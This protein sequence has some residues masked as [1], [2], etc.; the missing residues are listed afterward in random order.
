MI[1]KFI[2]FLLVV[3][4]TCFFA[5]EIELPFELSQDKSI[6]FLKLPMENQKDSLLFFFDTGA[7]IALLDAKKAIELGLEANTTNQVSGAGGEKT[8]AMIQNYKLYL[9][10]N[11]FINSIPVIT[12]DLTRLNESLAKKIDGIIGLTILKKYITKLDFK[13]QIMSLYPLG[14]PINYEEYEKIPFEL[15]QSSILQIPTTITLN[16]N[17]SF[18]GAS[19]FDS[20]ASITFLM[21]TPYKEE[22]EIVKKM[23]NT[24]PYTSDNLSNTTN[25]EKGLIRSIQIGG[26][27][28]ENQNLAISLSSD[29]EGVSSAPS[30]MGILGSKIIHRFDYI[31]DY[32]TKCIYLKPN[33]IF[34]TPFDTSS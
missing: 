19:L 1:H 33:Y 28:F 20:G 29:Q 15:Y 24:L 16:T 3:N 6:I 26:F 21:N 8:Y 12:E 11:H 23:S 22:H 34:D 30:I 10:S 25:Y 5:Q 4:S 31:I 14:T 7:S 13:T 2:L 18:T 32:S 27:I 17:E 9:D